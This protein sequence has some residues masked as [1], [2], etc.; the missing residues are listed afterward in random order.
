MSITKDDVVRARVSSQLKHHAEE[1]LSEIEIGEFQ[2]SYRLHLI[3][4]D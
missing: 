4:Y 1:V 3:V 2:A